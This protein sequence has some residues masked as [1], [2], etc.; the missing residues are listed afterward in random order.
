MDFMK[1][2][3]T[4]LK[5]ATRSEIYDQLTIFARAAYGNDISLDEGT[6]FE[7]FIGMLA[8]ALST[9]NGSAQ[10]LSELFSTKEL[11]GNFLDFVAGQ[12]G[13]VRK[14]VRNQRVTM[15]VTVDEHVTRPFLASRNSIF[16]R[17]GK[18]RTWVN[19]TQLMIQQSKFLPNGTFDTTENFQGT[20]EFGL[21][22]LNGYDSDLLYANNF[23]SMK[24]MHAVPP[25][26]PLF[27]DHFT[28]MNKVNATPAVQDN[29]TDAQ[30]RARYDAA[31]YSNASATVEGLRSNLLKLTDYVRIVENLTGSDNV[32]N[33]N[34]YGLKAHSI[35]CIVGGVSTTNNSGAVG[36]TPQ[37]STDSGDVT[38]A[39]TIL[40]YKSLGCGVSVSADV[41][42][43]TVNIGG[44]EYYT[45]NFKVEIP[46]ETIVAE[47]P[48]T[49]L[50][51]NTVTFKVVL[52]TPPTNTNGALRNTVRERVSYALQEYV[53]GLQPGEKITTMDTVKAVQAVLSQYEQGLF[54]FVSSTP[55]YAIGNQILIYQKAVGGTATVVFSD[56]SSEA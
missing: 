33:D 11:S 7:V 53:A 17:D 44:K 51:D 4:G 14:T 29:E 40:N 15:T 28:F 34:P 38:V 16:I 46:I 19:T 35:W 32:S 31:V 42:N 39:Q 48:F 47:I 6:P 2:T 45:G 22:P 43:G 41:Q 18:G 10:S 25:S 37:E 36:S 21:M 20:C 30:L 3:D 56:E 26:D 54:D 1:L 13:I 8:D 27:I 55:S 24:E 50:V 5:I 52:Y 23:P 49:R 12:R 9:V